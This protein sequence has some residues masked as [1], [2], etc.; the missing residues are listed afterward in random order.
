MSRE[1]TISGM[2][3][4]LL[5]IVLVLALVWYAMNPAPGPVRRAKA[6]GGPDGEQ[7]E[8]ESPADV[9]YGLELIEEGGTRPYSRPVPIGEGDDAN[10]LEWPDVIDL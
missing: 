6:E 8:A 9:G 3:L 2:R 7:R 4:R 1:Q 5:A 10:D